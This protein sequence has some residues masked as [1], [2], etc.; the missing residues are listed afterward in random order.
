MEVIK[1]NGEKEEFSK[2]KFLNSLSKS[3]FSEDEISKAFDEISENLHEGITTDEIYNEALQILEKESNEVEPVIKYSLKKAV[4]ELGPS[5][6]PFEKLVSRIYQEKGYK[7]ET[8]IMLKGKCI[9][10]EVDVIAY[11]DKELIIIEA[12]FHN[13]QR[14]KSDTK[15]ALYIKARIDDLLDSTYEIDGKEYKMSSA[16]LITNTGFTNNSKRYVECVGT[17][18]MISWSYPKNSGLLKMIEE[19]KIHPVTSIPQLSKAEKFE[20]INQG[21]IYCKDLLDDPGYLERANITGSKRDEVMKTAGIICGSH[22]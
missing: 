13:D 12:K 16:I 1:R 7:V 21:C 22:K 3:G 15:V 18:K 20:L 14:L 9:D 6:F 2:E 10:H 8:G 5:G 19:V 17:F 4:L 11:N